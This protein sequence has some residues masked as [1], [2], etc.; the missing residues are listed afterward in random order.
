MK[1]IDLLKVLYL[2]TEVQIYNANNEYIG[3]FIAMNI[4]E[5]LHDKKVVEIFINSNECLEIWIEK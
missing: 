4:D 2:Y 5:S 3:D 1:L